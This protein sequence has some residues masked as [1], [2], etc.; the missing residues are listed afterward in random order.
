MEGMD[1]HELQ[2]NWDK[3]GEV[4]PLWAIVSRPNMKDNKWDIDEFFASG[5]REVEILL[6]ELKSLNLELPDGQALDFGCGIGRVTQPLS[7]HFELC[8]GIDIAPSMIEMAR[9]HNKYG[10]R[11][12]YHLN[13]TD[14]LRIFADNSINFVLS[15]ITFQNIAPRYSK[16]YII[17][18]LRILA[19]QGLIVFQIPSEP[20]RLRQRIKQKLPQSVL[21]QFYRFKYQEAPVMELHGVHR[22]E[23]VK[24]IKEYQGVILNI[25]E[26]KRAFDE[27]TSFHYYVT[28]S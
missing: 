20:K 17:E 8:H 15:L 5:E 1:L 4:D 21:K 25:R 10:D 19:P 28:K 26:D 9:K 3:F 13:E 11:C 27:W 2:E 6:A 18:F 23:V 16:K 12:Q 14:D 7:Q 24:L 22:D